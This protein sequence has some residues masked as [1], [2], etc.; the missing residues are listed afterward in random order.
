M[1]RKASA[2]ELEYQSP[3]QCG[4][5]DGSPRREGECGTSEEQQ[6]QIPSH[7]N[8]YGV[9]VT[10]EE[11]PTVLREL[12]A[13]LHSELHSYPGKTG[14]LDNLKSCSPSP[15]DNDD[16]MLRFV[17]AERYDTRLAARRIVKHYEKKLELF[18]T[19]KL[20][21]KIVLDDLDQGDMKTLW[22]GGFQFL[23]S[24][25]RGGRV[26]LYERFQN[27]NYDMP[28]NL[29][30]TVWYVSMSLIEGSEPK[31]PLVLVDFQTG[32][33]SPDMFDRAVYKQT[34]N[35]LVK[36]MPIQFAGFHFC[37]DD[38]RFRMVWGLATIYLGKEA[39]QRAIDHEGTPFECR[40]GLMSYGINVDDLPITVDGV[41]NN[42]NFL[43]W[44]EEQQEA[45]AGANCATIL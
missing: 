14:I 33:F 26:I 25:D 13:N 28:E 38:V 20:G 11:T 5:K 41:D 37:F 39:K 24:L 17:R 15:L 21:T 22:S 12:L 3:P 30:R 19:E 6:D 1:K 10:I 18:G 31:S 8:L 29:F 44:I 34:I 27:L 16:M 42:K 32:R 35:I 36:L 45:D 23:P 7:D 4:F 43:R 2:T 9:E 40:Y